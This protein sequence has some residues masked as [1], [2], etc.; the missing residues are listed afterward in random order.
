NGDKEIICRPGASNDRYFHYSNNH[1]VWT[2]YRNNPR[3]TNAEYEDI[4]VYDIAQKSKERLSQKGR[5]FSPVLNRDAS[6]VYV[7]K[8]NL[9][10]SCVLQSVDRN[11]LAINDLYSFSKDEYISRLSLSADDSLMVFIKRKYNHAALFGLDLNN[12]KEKQLSPWSAHAIGA[13]RIS[14]E[15]LYFSASY[16]QRDNIYRVPLDG[17]M[18]VQQLTEAKAGFYQ[19]SANPS[20][21]ELLFTEAIFN[22][23]ALSKLTKSKWKK[24][25]I[26]IEE[27]L[28]QD[29][30]YDHLNQLPTFS[31]QADTTFDAPS[32]K[33]NSF[34]K[35]FRLH[36]WPITASPAAQEMDLIFN[37]YLNDWSASVGGG[38]NHNEK[39]SFYQARLSYGKFLP[40]LSATVNSNFRNL[41]SIWNDYY[42]KS[43][44][45]RS[46]AV[47]LGASIPLNWTQGNYNLGVNP[48]LRLQHLKLYRNE[49]GI[50]KN[51]NFAHAALDFSYLRRRARQ[52]LAPRWGIRTN[53]NYSRNAT[54]LSEERVQAE[55]RLYLP[56]LFANHSLQLSGGFRRELQENFYQHTD[57]F[58]YARGFEAPYSDEYQRLSVDYKLPLLY[59]DWGFWGINYFKR[60][61]A[62]FFFD[63]GKQM[64]Y[65]FDYNYEFQSTGVELFID[66]VF[67]N[68]LPIS[69][70]FRTSYLISEDPSN[71]NKEIA[72][73]ILISGG[74]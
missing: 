29:W 32:K 49:S 30:H 61:R 63:Y 28:E 9:D 38:Y 74:F 1:L 35:G 13:P 24:K 16:N 73:G 4:I 23:Y 36:S 31:Q 47:S 11:S 52:N 7:L 2:E 71:P 5:Y 43:N 10:Q 57:F 48:Q 68:A 50:K 14:E 26:Q 67:M 56:G 8:V 72:Y 44:R 21:N 62:N 27:P 59:P 6:L 58:N 40:V 39:G 12:F 20:G 15:S 69:L 55:S 46:D 34:T 41:A 70:G 33:Y 54:K 60:L 53:L 42:L 51:Y 3:R 22:G 66:N 45:F 37:N 65:A 25:E 64:L 19:A 18:D 17:S